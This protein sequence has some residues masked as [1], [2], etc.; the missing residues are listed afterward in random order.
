MMGNFGRFGQPVLDDRQ[1]TP[2]GRASGLVTKTRDHRNEQP[3]SSVFFFD[4]SPVST[5]NHHNMISAWFAVSQKM[6]PMHRKS[7]C[8]KYVSSLSAFLPYF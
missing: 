4:G 6:K 3:F 2:R 7:S 1:T 5:L 8:R